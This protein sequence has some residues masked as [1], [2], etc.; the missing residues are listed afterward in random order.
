MQ[1][2][3]VLEQMFTDI[4][5]GIE[6]DCALELKAVAEQYPFEPFVMKPMRFTFAEAVKARFHLEP[7]VQALHLRWAI[8][9][10]NIEYFRLVLSVFKVS[11]PTIQSGCPSLACTMPPCLDAMQCPAVIGM[12]H[13]SIWNHMKNRPRISELLYL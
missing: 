12:S 5:K 11:A 13:C 8:V 2:L 1:V 6:A 7:A 9:P 3:D 4:F 10:Q